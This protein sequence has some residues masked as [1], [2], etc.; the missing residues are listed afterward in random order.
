MSS[1]LSMFRQSDVKVQTP[2]AVAWEMFHPAKEG[3]VGHD[4]YC[5][6]DPARQT[7]F[8]RLLTRWRGRPCYVLWP[9]AVRSVHSTIRL[10]IP[11]TL[12]VFLDARSSARK[13]NID[14]AGGRIIDSGYRGELFTILRN[15]GFRP[16]LIEEGER[17]AQAVFIPA[18]RPYL[19]HTYEFDRMD[20][21][22]RGAAGFG[23]TGQ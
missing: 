19:R 22:A 9:F 8:D 17:Y 15:M 16:R 6:I 21:S 23:S 18:A 14:V 5:R 10:A 1:Q 11:H 2:D 13:K 3:D 20:L 7:W 12:W 4:L